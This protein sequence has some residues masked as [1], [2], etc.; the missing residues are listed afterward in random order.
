MKSWIG[1]IGSKLVET[2]DSIGNAA[3]TLKKGT[4]AKPADPA[5][6]QGTDSSSGDQSCPVLAHLL[7]NLRSHHV[8]HHFFKAP[9]SAYT[10]TQEVSVLVGSYNVA[11]KPPPPGLDLAPW[12]G[13]WDTVW[14]S[15]PGS[16]AGGG[17]PGIVAVGFQEV[18]P[19][20]AG[21]VIVGSA[22]H[23]LQAWDRA[24]AAQLNGEEWAAAEYPAQT[25]LAP[26]T[27]G[28][29]ARGPSNAAMACLGG[30]EAEVVGLSSQPV[31]ARGRYV[32]VAARQLVGTYL[33]VWV[34]RALLPHVRG[35]Q[36]CSVATGFGGYL[37]NKGA[38][39]VRLQ[40]FDSPLVLVNA[41]LSAGEQEGDELRRNADV[42][43]ILRRADFNQA[44]GPVPALNAPSAALA[45]A[46]LAPG[47]WGD[48]RGVTDTG[49]AIWLGDLNYRL[50]P[51][52]V[53]DA[54]A[55]KHLRAG[56]LQ[57]LLE[58][59]Q[60][61]REMAAGRVFVNSP[62]DPD[63]GAG[64]RHGG[65]RE[66]PITFAP[67]YKFRAGTH[68]Y[69]GDPLPGS[70]SKQGLAAVEVEDA[71][72][73][74]TSSTDILGAGC[75]D[76]SKQP[77]LV[78]DKPK[79]RRTPAWCDRVLWYSSRADLH[80]LAYQRGE[81]TAS[82]HKPVSAAFLLKARQYDR[83]T[84]MAMLDEA[85]RAVD[86]QRALARPKCSL[87]PN[88][89]T[90]P[91]PVLPF[92]PVTVTTTLKNEG[93]VDGVFHFVPP[94]SSLEVDDDGPAL[95]SWL[96]AVVGEGVVPPGGSVALELEVCVTG[97]LGG[98]LALQAPDPGAA[99]SCLDCIA[100][101]RVEDGGD[102]FLSVTGNLQYTWLGLPL[103]KLLART[104]SPRTPLPQPLPDTATDAP[105]TAASPAPTPDLPSASPQ[106]LPSGQL[107]ASC[108]S[109]VTQLSA[110]GPLAALL[111]HAMPANGNHALLP[112]ACTALARGAADSSGATSRT[113]SLQP[114]LLKA[115]LPAPFAACAAWLLASESV[116]G[117]SQAAA[118][119]VGGVG[120][121]GGG[122]GWPSTPASRAKSVQLLPVQGLFTTSASQVLAAAAPA[123]LAAA[124]ARRPKPLVLGS[125][126]AGGASGS[127]AG[128]GFGGEGVGAGVDAV[129]WSDAQ[130][131]HS[132]LRV[133]L[134]LS[135]VVAEGGG[136]GKPEQLPLQCA[137]QPTG[138]SPA[139]D[140]LGKAAAGEE[141]VRRVGPQQQQQQYVEVGSPLAQHCLAS[142]LMAAVHQLPSPLLPP[143]LLQ[144]CLTKVG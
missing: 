19:L 102:L 138:S 38:V 70:S 53:S 32:Q 2:A 92:I 62:A 117:S 67:T 57:P 45:S 137:M 135:R 8:R 91:D 29:I 86:M 7:R 136:A 85:R 105:E 130:A 71:S 58:A 37:G 17:F 116:P 6:V 59:D 75:D 46:S 16:G 48:Q 69:V 51:T 73:L 121:G 81:L 9:A 80:Q 23:N 13:L 55:R 126:S 12:L 35:V 4:E 31:Q 109:L 34:S 99:V 96:R 78:G 132:L 120:G 103:P 124:I 43:E 5:A 97:G 76:N 39:L 111:P 112:T 30:L 127:A 141:E 41:H 104:T 140:L 74:S 65:W 115:L 40:V 95:P 87:H 107:L 1:K 22:T 21:N 24:I 90:L 101:L 3:Q 133:L 134:P 52:A 66:G 20:N 118:G 82:D 14:P 110:T 42:A 88:L 139:E 89:L 119:G 93:A 28:L 131:V 15:V 54:D 56:R 106:R 47:Y 49:C 122:A 25:E 142:L 63:A 10:K 108:W 72:P 68:T 129:I 44:A 50:V 113:P 60:L 83:A 143:P 33:S 27:A 36:S 84:V 64:T 114:A 94:P 98:A 100:I 61:G 128:Q 26:L 125:E 123:A 144:H 79:S 77:G 11:G 18:V